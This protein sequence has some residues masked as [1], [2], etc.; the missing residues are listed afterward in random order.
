MWVSAVMALTACCAAGLGTTRAGTAVPLTATTTRLTTLTTTSV[1]ALPEFIALLET[2]QMTRLVSSPV[3][4]NFNLAKK[5][6][7]RLR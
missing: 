5:T 1:F 3:L 6:G 2:A 7:S 4:V